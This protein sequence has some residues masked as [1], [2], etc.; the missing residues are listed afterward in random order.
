[1]QHGLNNTDIQKANRS[2]V[3]KI[4]LT[5][6]PVSR[7]ELV[8]K[9][10]LRK[11]TITNIINEF[12]EMGIIREEGYTK[13]D[14]GRR[15]EAFR[16]DIPQL[17]ILSI[18][19]T[20]K[21]YRATLYDLAGEALEQY[22]DNVSVD[23][24]IQ[25]LLERV[26]DQTDAMLAAYDR[27]NVL[28]M[29]IA[30]PGPYIRRK[31]KNVAI[32]TGFANLSKTDVEKAFAQR[33][34]FKVLTEHDAKLAAF[35][36]WKHME[37]EDDLHENSLIQIQ[38]IGMGVGSGAVINGRILEGA[39][40]V[41]GEIGH[42]GINFNGPKNERDNRGAFEY[43]AGTEA[44][45]RYLQEMLYQYPESALKEDSKYKEIRQ[46]YCEGDE[47]ARAVMEK[48]AWMLGYGI[49]NMAFVLNPSR[50]VVGDDYP[51][52]EG[53]MSM[54][55]QTV[56]QLVYTEVYENMHIHY[57]ELTQDSTLLGGYYYVL[58]RYLNNN[59]IIDK[60]RAAVE[61]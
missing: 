9:T 34:P 56:E 41:A 61:R 60:V 29:C 12:L 25:I 52:T 39:I 53:F 5:E 23:E 21:F 8:K 45:S 10:R 49:A 22:Q 55:K 43:Y 57:S 3:I 4:M 17:V 26:M 27:K 32:V 47:L 38:S 1:M 24:D 54:V 59:G 58:E 18:R 6:G 44:C 30:L 36:E 28:G 33:Y 2:L 51:Q 46:A 48:L 37:I 42:M 11:A 15:T 20:S 35:A 40:G 31:D 16:I 19:F 13:A 50:V 7:V 14:A